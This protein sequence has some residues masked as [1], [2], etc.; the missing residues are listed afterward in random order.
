MTQ[1]HGPA[2][3]DFERRNAAAV[4][5]MNEGRYPA[6]LAILRQVGALW[7]GA[8]QI[9]GNLGNV[10]AHHLSWPDCFVR[11]RR[12][13]AIDARNPVVHLMLGTAELQCGQL[14]PG[15]KT[16]RRAIQLRPGYSSA[17]ANLGIAFLTAQNPREA[18]LHLRKAIE[19]DRNHIAARASLIR[20]LREQW[21][22]PDAVV[23]ARK[24]I[25]LAPSTVPA[26]LELA[27]VELA[28]G[29]VQSAVRGNRRALDCE[30]D[31]LVATSSYL[32]NLR[33]D[34]NVGAEAV[35][36][37]HLKLGRRVAARALREARTPFK[38]WSRSTP[39]RV[40]FVSSDF[41]RTPASWFLMSALASRKPGSWQAICYADV[42]V[43]DAVTDRLRSHADLWRM[44][45]GWTDEHLAAT[46]A[47][48]RIDVL[49]DLSGHA[50]GSRLSLYARR[51]AP[52]Q[53]TWLGYNDTT[54]IP[55]MDFILAD[56][57]VIPP[58][59]ERHFGERVVRLRDG[60]VCYSPPDYAP[61]VAPL[62]S[63]SRG[64]FTFGCFGQLAKVTDEVLQNWE[65][66]LAR[67]PGSRLA[68]LSPGLDEPGL[69]ARFRER[70]ARN[71][72]PL[73]R[74]EIKRL[75]SIR[76]PSRCTPIPT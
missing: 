6:A 29:E 60:F 26:L 68:L 3:D 42:P 37:A 51:A 72:I 11:Y 43:G 50:A 75:P 13:L 71:G 36:Q 65:R 20:A 61:P 45:P 24:T 15:M 23:E 46:I 8:L 5:A 27:N 21:Q 58:G 34:P 25:A 7:P 67:T 55:N 35:A 22:L 62:P 32:F 19:F 10:A 28:M 57:F 18:E 44:I 52:I 74:V 9:H 17:Y 53:V 31:H 48:D 70:L 54:G 40:G 12:A 76:N 2:P 4:Q 49:F 14:T 64:Y 1:T 33:F 69:R 63:L 30:P 47:A 59:E 41:R 73:D 56:R 66:I 39:L 38:G 16:L